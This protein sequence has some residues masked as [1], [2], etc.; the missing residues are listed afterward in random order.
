MRALD[1]PADTPASSEAGALRTHPHVRAEL[2]AGAGAF[3]CETKRQRENL[4]PDGVEV[5]ARASGERER[6]PARAVAAAAALVVTL[7]PEGPRLVLAGAAPAPIAAALVRLGAVESTPGVW[8]AAGESVGRDRLRQAFGR[9][10]GG[11]PTSAELR[12]A[13]ELARRLDGD[14]C[15]LVF[16]AEPPQS[17]RALLRRV[18]MRPERVEVPDLAGYV[19]RWTST[20][21]ATAHVAAAVVRRMAAEADAGQVLD[22]DRARAVARPAAPVDASKASIAPESPV[23]HSPAW[24]ATLAELREV[25]GEDLYRSTFAGLSLVEVEVE[26]ERL[27]DE[28]W[29]VGAVDEMGALVVGKSYRDVIEAC[30]ERA[31]GRAVTVAVRYVGEVA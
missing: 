30:A 12:R 20:E 10:A 3:P 2:R 4:S 28:T 24:A 17:V 5:G 27:G 18:G 13:G 22:I 8:E 25:V 9:L 26:G 23:Q 7:D 29:T 14:R 21:P 16:R 19:W 11:A 6:V 1:T 15:E 31:T